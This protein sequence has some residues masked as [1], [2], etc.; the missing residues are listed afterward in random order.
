[1]LKKVSSGIPASGVRAF[2]FLPIVEAGGRK[3]VDDVCL[4][5]CA[6]NES[7]LHMLDPRLD[8]I[9]IQAIEGGRRRNYC[10]GG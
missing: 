5:G 8:N 4:I 9:D 1:M 6:N 3:P 7:Q 2:C 10:C